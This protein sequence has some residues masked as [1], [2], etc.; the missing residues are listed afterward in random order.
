MLLF[1]LAC[2]PA[3]IDSAAPTPEWEVLAS[4]LPG[5]LLSVQA[6]SLEHLYLLGA[7][8]TGSPMIFFL[9]EDRW[10]ELSLASR[11]DL[12]WGFEW[13]E[14]LWVVGDGGRVLRLENGQLAEETILDEMAV[15]FGIWG[16]SPENLYAVGSDGSP[17]M[18]HF[19]GEDWSDVSLPEGSGEHTALFK[20]WG[21]SASE[22]WAIGA[23]GLTLYWDGAAWVK[24]ESPTTES[25]FTLH[26]NSE[27]LYAVGGS[28]QGV[29][30]RWED[31]WIDESPPDAAQL[32]GVY[33]RSQG[34]DPI[35]VGL[36]GAVWWRRDGSWQPDPIPTGTTLGF[37]A[38]WLD[39]YC[40][41]WLV[42]G[43]LASWPMTDGIL[44]HR[45]EHDLPILQAEPLPEGEVDEEYSALEVLE[46]SCTKAEG[47]AYEF[48]I[49][50][51]TEGARLTVWDETSSEEHDLPLHTMH[52]QGYWTRWRVELPITIASEQEAG[53][54][55]RYGCDAALTWK[56]DRLNAGGE[57]NE[58]FSWGA[59]PEDC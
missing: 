53:V 12:W 27:Q 10:W 45:G 36:Y 14:H 40:D 57:V 8:A 49:D 26:G 31:G 4:G 52:P 19:D 22:V 28:S 42:G 37:H 15:L 32:N 7:D 18:W 20:V 56:V 46:S 3:P 24:L 43:A 17:R 33:V 54:S 50:G 25:L 2:R 47:W 41:P 59:A 44:L 9:D 39:P 38:A 16:T 13:G 48:Q 55:T 11:G 51:S 30:L 5:A 29:I 1:L 23:G 6:R 34:C 35:A 58:C 21:R